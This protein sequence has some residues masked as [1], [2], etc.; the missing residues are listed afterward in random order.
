MVLFVELRHLD[1]PEL[2][3]VKC[4]VAGYSGVVDKNVNLKVASPGM[5]KLAL[6]HVNNVWRASS[7]IGQVGL[8]WYAEGSVRALKLLAEMA[9]GL[10]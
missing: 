1:R 10:G 8:Q 9:G 3:I 7:G 4:F 6:G 2:W 5:G